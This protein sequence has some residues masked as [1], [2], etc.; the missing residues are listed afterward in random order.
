MSGWATVPMAT[1]HEALGVAVDDYI[2]VFASLPQAG[3]EV[4]GQNLGGLLGLYVDASVGGGIGRLPAG[5]LAGH[6]V[7]PAARTPARV[8]HGVRLPRR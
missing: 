8:V 2:D 6:S 1:A 3:V 4:V 7:R 5:T